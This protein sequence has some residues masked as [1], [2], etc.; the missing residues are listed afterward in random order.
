MITLHQDT[1]TIFI[2][3][4]PAVGNV[5]D[6]SV[7]YSPGDPFPFWD[8]FGAYQGEAPGD[9]ATGSGGNVRTPGGDPLTEAGKGFARLGFVPAPPPA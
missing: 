4:H 1:W 9:S 8:F 7:T 2:P 3:D 6:V 5:R